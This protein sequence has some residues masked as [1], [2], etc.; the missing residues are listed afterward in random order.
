MIGVKAVPPIWPSE[1][2][3]MHPPDISGI[4]SP[5]SR[6]LVASAASSAAIAAVVQAH[7]P[8]R[9]AHADSRPARAHRPFE[10]FRAIEAAVDQPTVKADRMAGAQ[11]DRRQQQKHGK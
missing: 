6:A 10:P 3:V 9:T 1:V 8:D 5:F 2:M 11:G 7:G 4:D